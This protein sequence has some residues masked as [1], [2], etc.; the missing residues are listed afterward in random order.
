MP[1]KIQDAKKYEGYEEDEVKI[2]N[3]LT[4]NEGNAFTEE[5][6][7]EGIGKKPL[8]STPDEKGSN[9]TWQNV[10][11]FTLNVISGVSFEHTLEE[12]VKKKRIHVREVDGKKYYFIEETKLHVGRIP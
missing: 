6:I 9:W 12:M 4:K 2:A 5:E 7:E 10:A 3:F 8:V 1:I 11:K